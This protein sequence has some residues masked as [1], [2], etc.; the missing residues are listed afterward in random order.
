MVS[1]MLNLIPAAPNFLMA[2]WRTHVV[3]EGIQ[4]LASTVL[5]ECKMD[6]LTERIVPN[7]GV[8]V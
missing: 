8:A 6:R 3:S 4:F 7:V 1:S 2:F 5:R